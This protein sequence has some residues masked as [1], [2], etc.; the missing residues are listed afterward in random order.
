M[1]SV[2]RTDWGPVKE[3]SQEATVP[4]HVRPGVL[5]TRRWQCSAETQP[6]LGSI[7]KVEPSGKLE[8]GYERKMFGRKVCGDYVAEE[9]DGAG[10]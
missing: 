5:G 10:S 1:A 3:A 4:G 6:N 8:V 2:W 7:F 9:V